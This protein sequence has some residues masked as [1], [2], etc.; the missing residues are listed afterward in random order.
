MPF[1]QAISADRL[2]KIPMS[3]D[4][5]GPL[6][7]DSLQNAFR[8]CPSKPISSANRRLPSPD[9]GHERPDG[10]H[11]GGR[12]SEP[13]GL[14][15][16]FWTRSVRKA[17]RG[18]FASTATSI[19]GRTLG[20]GRPLYFLN[21]ADRDT[22]ICFACWC[23]CCGTNFA[24]SCSTIRRARIAAA[25]RKS[26][27]AEGLAADLFAA[28]DW[29]GDQ[30]LLLVRD[31]VRQCRRACRAGSAAARGSS[32]RFCKRAL[33]IGS[34][35]ATERLLCAAWAAS[36]PAR[37]RAVPFCETIQRANHQRYFPPFDASRWGFFVENAG[38]TPIRD[39]AERAALVGAF[40]YRG[41]S[42]RNPAADPLGSFGTRRA[43]VGRRAATELER[44]LPHATT[45]M[46]HTTG[47]LAHLTHPHRL[48]KLVRAFL[49]DA[50]VAG[51][52]R[53]VPS[54]CDD[55]HADWTIQG[56]P[57]KVSEK[58]IIPHLQPG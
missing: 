34:L 36:F 6:M 49:S 28:A 10:H 39:A 23:G 20:T 13:A 43:R 18:R 32:G 8:Q 41:R 56:R 2:D 44:G 25:D 58:P 38:R 5:P 45:E 19:S 51:G 33:P 22:R 48:A 7:A 16:R 47:P 15:R 53:P 21:G 9:A 31:V 17:R 37:W 46:L 57:I 27:T 35:S 29:H 14:G 11:H 26:L 24:A 54:A 3:L 52:E 30:T 42:G 1:V 40:D 55:A 12:L 50:P 4:I